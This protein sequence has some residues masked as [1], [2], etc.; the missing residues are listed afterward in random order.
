MTRAV[1]V[2]GL[3]LVVS[4]CNPLAPCLSRQET[5]SVTTVTG[6]VAVGHIVVHRVRYG[7]EGSQNDVRISWT[8]QHTSGGPRIGVSAT[9]VAGQDFVPPAQEGGVPPERG[10][11]ETIGTSAGVAAPDSG[12]AAHVQTFLIISNG[13]GNPDI[14]GTPAEYKLWVVGDHSQ[15]VI[16]TMSITFF[17]GPD[18]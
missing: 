6:E 17:S 7:T 9:R 10:A 16:Y 4:G 11:C 18:C 15:R 1:A 13:Q 5:G 3:A 12:S 2:A 8:G 14:L